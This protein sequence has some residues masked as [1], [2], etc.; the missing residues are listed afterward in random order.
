MTKKHIARRIFM[1]LKQKLIFSFTAVLAVFSTIMFIIIASRINKLVNMNL[2]NNLESSISLGY[3]Y[4]D[5]KHPG[6][7]SIKEGKLY[8]GEALINDNFEVV[9][10]IKSKE[11][12]VVT[13]FMGDT[14]VSTN[15]INSDGKRAVGSKASQE[16]VEKV[17]K[18]GKEFSGPTLIN[19]KPALYTPIK[20]GT[21]TVIGIW[22]VGIVKAEINKEIWNI[23][24]FFGIIILIMLIFG[25]IVSV[26]IGKKMVKVIAG[27]NHQFTNMAKGDFSEEISGHHLKLKD[28]LGD[29]AR[30]MKEMQ[31]KVR[32]I[33]ETVVDESETIDKSASIS[34]GNITL[35]NNNIEDVSSTTEEISAGLEETAASMEEMNA[36]SEEINQSVEKISVK[37]KEGTKTV[38]E[39]SLR[40]LN[41]KEGAVYSQNHANEIYMNTN[42]KLTS[43]IEQ[44]KAIDEIKILSESIL[45]ITKQ[46][47]LL[48][49]NAAIEA[50]RAGEAGRGFSV[51]AEEI[52]KLA[53][54]SNQAVNRIQIVIKTALDSVENLANSSREALDFIDKQV[55]RDYD[56]MV[57]TGEE[58]SNDAKYIENIMNE[59]N[60]MAEGLKSSIDTMV[61]AINDV[62]TAANQGAEGAT[63][64]AEKSMNVVSE[65]NEVVRIT[66]EVKHSADKLKSYITQFKIN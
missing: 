23:L 10:K 22:S 54:S 62:T 18:E 43:A 35:L 40:A 31:R 47:N 27:I 33:V 37:A 19:G 36:T 17:L 41:L 39:I 21:G 56:T 44:S 48:A 52:R 49:L 14:R 29:M 5:A 60:G 66:E 8:K 12:E 42:K 30:A 1:K 15:V 58:Y 25:I 51:V 4:L 46:T 13:I 45:Q 11:G 65:G 63:I 61:V 2:T 32:D 6:L 7:W 64:I 3:L 53:E 28:E 9:D 34:F 55:I 24:S 50:S 59:F 57:K 26:F 16:V 20:D 38:K